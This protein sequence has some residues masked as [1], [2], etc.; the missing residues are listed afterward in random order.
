MK[1]LG[2]PH[3]ITCQPSLKSLVTNTTVFAHHSTT[4][5]ARRIKSFA[6]SSFEAGST[7]SL[8]T[9]PHKEKQKWQKALDETQCK[10]AVYTGFGYTFEHRKPPAS[11][12][13][14]EALHC[15]P[16]S[17][18]QESNHH[19]SITV[20]NQAPFKLLKTPSNSYHQTHHSNTKTEPQGTENPLR[21]FNFFNQTSGIFLFR[22]PM[23]AAW[24]N[25]AALTAVSQACKAGTDSWGGRASRVGVDLTPWFP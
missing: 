5:L 19:R 17:K 15:L 23:A 3:N 7:A 4:E 20:P 21:P 10:S 11:R 6:I 14:L 8:F 1:R 13:R 24:A 2:D 22:N 12:L 16:S 18:Y 25:D 9:F